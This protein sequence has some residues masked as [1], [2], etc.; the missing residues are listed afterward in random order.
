MSEDK[1]L[2]NTMSIAEAKKVI[3]EVI[4]KEVK[5]P[6]YLW[7]PPGVGKSSIIKQITQ[8]RSLEFI[9]LRLRL[10]EPPDLRGL[11]YIDKESKLVRWM[12]PVFLP[13]EGKGILTL[14]ELNVCEPSLQTTAYQL[15]FDKRVGE[16]KLGGEWFIIATGNRE[17]DNAVTFDIPSPL[18]NRFIH[19]EIEPDLDA[20][21]LYAFNKD[22]APQI[23]SYLNWKEEHLYKQFPGQKAFP[24]PRS[25]EFVSDVI[26]KIGLQAKTLIYGSVGSVAGEFISFC[27]LERKLP[28]I[29]ALLNGSAKM[30]E[31][32]SLQFLIIGRLIQEVK[33]KE[34]KVLKVLG[35]FQSIS[36]EIQVVA[37][38]DLF[39]SATSK[40]QKVILQS[41]TWSKFV[42]EH[43]KDI[44]MGA[45]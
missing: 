14:E 1:L 5:T 22:L 20:F 38:K 43:G 23:I 8:E 42:K 15:T 17:E 36:P 11:P 28:S 26:K 6:I 2:R 41:D 10:L 31:E 37:Y 30:P 35:I 34:S 29:E 45:C 7:G 24:S 40:L 4:D 19:L 33:K 9:D 16:H 27:E 21:K 3:G 13:K 44:A 18:R 32:L 25:W 39:N 12:R